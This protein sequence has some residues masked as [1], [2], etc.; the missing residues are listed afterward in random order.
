MDGNIAFNIYSAAS[1]SPHLKL[2]IVFDRIKI[3]HFKMFC[4]QVFLT[5]FLS[6]LHTSHMYNLKCS[7]LTP[8][9]SST[10]I[11]CFI[12]WCWTVRTIENDNCGTF[13]TKISEFS[14]NKYLVSLCHYFVILKYFMV[15]VRPG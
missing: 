12:I 11:S 10:L 2:C 15:K 6:F 3:T 5:F 13:C 1:L 9:L 7:S 8:V 4:S 14:Q